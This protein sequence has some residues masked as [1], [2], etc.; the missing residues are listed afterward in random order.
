MPARPRGRGGA[1]RELCGDAA[2][3][4]GGSG[5]GRGR[6]GCRA[7]R[8]DEYSCEAPAGAG[9]AGPVRSGGRRWRG[10]AAASA[11]GVPGPAGGEDGAGRAGAWRRGAGV[12]PPSSLPPPRLPPLQ[13]WFPAGRAVPAPVPAAPGRALSRVALPERPHVPDASRCRLAG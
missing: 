5:G 9:L 10:A 7:R 12:G 11:R 4:S 3:G 8:G 2:R 13:G 6:G 1:G